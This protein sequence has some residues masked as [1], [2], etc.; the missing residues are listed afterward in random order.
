MFHV[1]QF[2]GTDS[3][4]KGPRLTSQATVS[5]VFHVEQMPRACQP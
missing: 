3:S 4:L 5:K 2:F 1:E